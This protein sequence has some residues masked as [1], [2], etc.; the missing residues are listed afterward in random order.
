M[1]IDDINSTFKKIEKDVLIKLKEAGHN[2]TTVAFFEGIPLTHFSKT[3]IAF[4][5][6]IIM[7][8]KMLSAH[9]ELIGNSKNVLQP[10]DRKDLVDKTMKK[11]LSFFG[12]IMKDG[13]TPIVVFDGKIHPFKE[14]ELSKRSSIKNKKKDKIECLSTNFSTCNPLDRTQEMEDEIRKSL[15]NFIKIT[16]DDYLLLKNLLCNLGICCLDAPYDGEK[17]CASLSHENIVSAV[18]STDTDC[19]PLGVKIMISEISWDFSKGMNVC[20][21]VY[22]D[23]LMFLL[24]CYFGYTPTHSQLVDLCIIHGCDFNQRMMIPKKKPDPVNPYKSCGQQTGLDLI[25]EHRSFE[26]FPPIFYSFMGDLKIGN[27][28]FMFQYEESGIKDEDTNLD[29]N[30]FIKNYQGIISYYNIESYSKIHFEQINV[31]NLKIKNNT[32]IDTKITN[33]NTDVSYLG[34][35][36]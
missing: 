7:Y 30:I 31:N 2:V 29:W 15:K 28:R 26:N 21:V 24:Q 22:L 8:A 1:G 17:L 3:K 18:Y 33:T 25:K 12:S 6:S 13:I 20:K 19:Y 10:Y 11:I 4:D 34:F 36:F 14:E 32:I 35:S 23:R 16:K 5:V 27:C 9:N